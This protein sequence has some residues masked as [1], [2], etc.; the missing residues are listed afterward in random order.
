[1]VVGRAEARRE[2][3]TA[4]PFVGQLGRLQK[5]FVGGEAGEAPSRSRGAVGPP[6]RQIA[7]DLM[8]DDEGGELAHGVSAKGVHGVHPG[9]GLG[10]G[11]IGKGNLEHKARVP[12]WTA[13]ADRRRVKNH[14]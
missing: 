4:E 7:G 1:M 12:P 6:V 5:G 2:V 10:I 3:C 13:F 14:H 8:V 11:V 9:H